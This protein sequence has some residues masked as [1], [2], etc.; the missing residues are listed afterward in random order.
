[1]Q[2][3]IDIPDEQV[4]ELDRLSNER[5]STP[6]ALLQALVTEFLI[7]S[8]DAVRPERPDTAQSGKALDGAFGL[9]AGRG[10]DASV[11]IQNLRDEWDR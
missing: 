5:Q 6:A 8:Q 1:M 4:A 2:M 9:W 11:Y 10:I 3:T 7:P